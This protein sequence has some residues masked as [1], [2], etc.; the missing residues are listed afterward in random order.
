MRSL[1]LLFLVACAAP[2]FRFDEQEGVHEVDIEWWYHAGYL[3]DRYAFFSSFFRKRGSSGDTHR[4][5]IYDLIDLKTGESRYRSLI[6]KEAMPSLRAFLIMARTLRRDDPELPKWIELASKDILPAPHGVI[7]GA[8]IEKAGDPLRLAYGPNRLEKIADGRYR[9]AIE[10]SE[11]ALTLDLV[12]RAPAIY[13]GG[14]GL[15]GVD[16]HED[17]HYYTLPRLESE[18]SLTLKGKSEPIRGE[19]WYDHQW[20]KVWGNGK[21]GW[22]WWGIKLDDGEAINLYVLRDLKTGQPVRTV[23][24]SSRG[25]H[26]THFTCTPTEFWESPKTRVRYPVAW[27]I[28]GEGLNLEITPV[29]KERELDVL[30]DYRFIWEGPCVTKPAGRGFQELVGYPLEQKKP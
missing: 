30:G 29:F 12:D 15:T 24:S 21:V 7:G 16:K 6:G 9:L 23:A 25:R 5:L 4:Y 14:R 27:K 11:F 22:A 17:M 26:L 1:G 2:A 8:V 3:G 18:G 20:G 28:Q 10:D 13:V 19:L